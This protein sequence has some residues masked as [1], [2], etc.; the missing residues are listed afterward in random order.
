MGIDIAFGSVGLNNV[1][2][3]SGNTQRSNTLPSA[4]GGNSSIISVRVKK[5]ILD[6]SDMGLF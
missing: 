6:N 2:Y 5:I 1:V 4:A 3:T